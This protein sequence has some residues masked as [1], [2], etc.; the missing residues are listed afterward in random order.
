MK[1]L[2]TYAEVRARA[3]EKLPAFGG[4]N[5]LHIKRQVEVLLGLIGR[6][7]IFDE[8]TK[9]DI[10]HI[11]RMLETLDWLI[12]DDTKTIMSPADWLATVL[13][14]YF[15]DLGMLVTN[16]EYRA[17]DSSGF[18]E[19]RDRALF[20]GEYGA[21]YRAKVQGLKK[22]DSERFLYQEY[23]R[24]KHAERIRRWM[25]GQESQH[26]GISHDATHAIQ[27]LLAPLSDQF[28]RDVALVCES[29]HLDDLHDT[30]KYKISQP[31]GNSEE[32]TANLQYVAVL[33]R[34]ADLLHMTTDRTPSVAFKV[35]NPTDPLS[36]LEW[37][38]QMAVT[39]VRPQVGFDKENRPDPN[40]PR[41]TIEVHA[42]FKSEDGFFGLT[43]YLHYVASQLQR[44]NGWIENS[45]K[46]KGSRH[47]FPWRRVD[48]SGIETV[49]FLRNTYEFTID[50][51]KILDLLTG[52]TLYN[53]TRVVLRELVQNSLDAVR[54]QRL[55][56]Q[57]TNRQEPPGR[58]SIHW[59]TKERVL[60]VEDNG[61]GMTQQM[62]ER[63]L[64][65]VGSSRYQ[66]PE[67]KK[68]F[69][70]FA[71]ISRFGIGVLSAFM[72]ADTVEITTCHPDED[73]ARQL[74]LRSVHGKYL[75]RTIDKLSDADARNLA[76][77]GTRV[78]LRVR[79]SAK[80]PDP[81]VTARRWVV[82]PDCEVTVKVDDC[83]PARVGFNSPKEAL[84]EVLEQLRPVLG[85]NQD[86][87][88]PTKVRI[89][90]GEMHGVTVAF[91]VEWSE[92]FREWSFLTLPS[93]SSLHEEEEKIDFALGTC[94]GGIR[95]EF[96]TPGYSGPATPILAVSNASGVSAPKTNVARSGLESTEE[97]SRM[98]SAIY[99]IYCGHVASEIRNL[100]EKRSFSLT[101]ATREST[102]LL[103]PILPQREFD[104]DR[105]RPLS[106]RLLLNEVLKLPLLVI[107]RGGRRQS[108]SPAQINEDPAF[109]TIDCAFFRFA[110]MLIREVSTP[111]SISALGNSLGTH[112]LHLPEGP[113]VCSLP[114]TRAIEQEL[115]AVREVAEITIYPEQRRADFL[116]EPAAAPPRWI[117]LL[118]T[119][120][121]LA[122]DEYP[123]REDRPYFG[124]YE[125]IKAGRGPTTVTGIRDGLGVVSMRTLFLLPNA[126]LTRFLVRAWEQAEKGPSDM[127]K[128]ALVLYLLEALSFLI[129]RDVGP[130]AIPNIGAF[131]RSVR[132]T[133]YRRSARTIDFTQLVNDTDLVAFEEAITESN[134]EIFNPSAWSRKET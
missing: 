96:D 110:E 66:D 3:A 12:P 70:N 79:P 44:S 25:L 53:D 48:D 19:Y 71:A 77:H 20:G 93:R 60:T 134:W 95:V 55:Q 109:W 29:H 88:D 43:S 83:D 129:R 42:Y 127:T 84:A 130:Q 2:V 86:P 114:Q 18:P 4:L 41:D 101:W 126:P 68:Q 75:I 121:R 62:I 125:E 104:T 99:S 108:T 7:G 54:L 58:V 132:E 30:A 13:S 87:S 34:T 123:R 47:R 111:M 112:E 63:H 33:L 115:F 92:Y 116:W 98:L 52:H 57:Q 119:A 1:E 91:A 76:P 26:L 9:H 122:P 31:Y 133:S 94:V 22:D 118:R 120:R 11:D 81:V 45:A 100:Y 35:I 105:F 82:V 78:R 23:V 17:R 15:H 65:H 36:Q 27:D 51:A 85:R 117:D 74:S 124:E 40:A 69:P 46:L 38:K 24:E 106:Y 61:T 107:E 73:H 16:Q 90:Q 5:L 8:Y 37:A 14:V 113:V 39:C 64:L 128:T 72:V 89:E 103:E 102:F 49:G 67:F 50:Q 32:E 80:M 56:N 131:L 59:N 10:S 21:D 6:N 28:R 97:R